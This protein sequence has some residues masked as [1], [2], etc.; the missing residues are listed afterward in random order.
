MKNEE[1]KIDYFNNLSIKIIAYDDFFKLEASDNL[2]LLMKLIKKNLIPESN[3][4][5]KNKDILQTIYDKLIKYKE[6]N[7]KYL[8]TIINEKKEII[9][10]Y[11]ERFKLFKLIK[12]KKYDSKSEFN[13]VKEKYLEVKK[14]LKNAYKIS[15]LL[16]LYYKKTFKK[17]IDEINNIYNV[18]SIKDKNVCLWLSKEEE[19][20]GFISKYEN[21]AN[22]INTIKNI[23]LFLIIYN[24]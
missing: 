15:N 14:Y 16:T 2:K 24:E 21:K 9:N 6:T 10:I 8:D 11:S 17:E 19:I 12:G 20:K 5:E 4:L 23:K 13:K 22:L 18:Y 7:S 1:K 3:Y